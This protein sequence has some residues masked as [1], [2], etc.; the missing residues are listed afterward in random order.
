MITF[1]TKR[2]VSAFPFVPVMAISLA[3]ALS[4]SPSAAKAQ[5][6]VALEQCT[7]LHSA[8]W[9][10]GVTN[11]AALH[12]V[13]TTSNWECTGTGGLLSPAS[14]TN[15]FEATFACSGLLAPV[16]GLVWT[17]NWNDGQPEPTSTFSFNVTVEAVDGN[18]VITSNGGTITAGRFAGSSAVATF[19]LLG[20][21]GL[22]DNQ[23]EQPGGLTGA[24]G[25]TTLTIT[26]L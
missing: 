2:W 21:A 3:T 7:G 24:G 25:A 19:T 5:G 4:M 9:S 16:D 17:I 8:Q 1:R 18:L 23:C 15:E 11:T 26:Q 14:S 22:L 10:P 12:T 20:L 6:S 13:T